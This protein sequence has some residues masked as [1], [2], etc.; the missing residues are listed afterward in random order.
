M[1]D[2]E[3]VDSKEGREPFPFT[4]QQTSNLQSDS[5]NSNS[6]SNGS[7]NDKLFTNRFQKH[8]RNLDF[9]NH[10]HHGNSDGFDSQGLQSTFSGHETSGD[11]PSFRATP[12]SWREDEKENEKAQIEEIEEVESFRLSMS[13]HSHLSNHTEVV[14]TPKPRTSSMVRCISTCLVL[15]TTVVNYFLTNWASRMLQDE[16]PF[17]ITIAP[18][19]YLLEPPV[20]PL[21]YISNLVYND[22]FV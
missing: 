21:M 3:K 13:N 8:K 20:L 4:D 19:E 7:G 17:N 1:R 10:H 12:I 18:S 22:T 11:V 5:P 6:N 16:C 14:I 9:N 15:S 2:A